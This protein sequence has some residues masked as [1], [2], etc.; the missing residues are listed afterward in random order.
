MIGHRTTDLKFNSVV[1]RAVHGTSNLNQTSTSHFRSRTSRGTRGS[2]L[3]ASRRRQRPRPEVRLF[4]PATMST[5][6]LPPESTSKSSKIMYV[7]MVVCIW[8]PVAETCCIWFVKFLQRMVDTKHTLNPLRSKTKQKQVFI[9]LW[10][11]TDFLIPS[12]FS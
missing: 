10:S 3:T 2:S 11:G 9:A 1:L 12:N 5:E 8:T 4:E 6:A 7:L